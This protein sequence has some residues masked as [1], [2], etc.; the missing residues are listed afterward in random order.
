MRGQREGGDCPLVPKA[1]VTL[2]GFQGRA[3]A[4]LPLPTPHLPSQT[5]LPP[6]F[7]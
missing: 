7:G 2:P 6:G 5:A 3:K 4:Y 1:G